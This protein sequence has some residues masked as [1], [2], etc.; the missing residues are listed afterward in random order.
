MSPPVGQSLHGR[1]LDVSKD[2]GIVDLTLKPELVK[3]ADAGAAGSGHAQE[4]AKSKS[5]KRKAAE[6]AL[7]GTSQLKVTA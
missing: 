3:A 4:K 2:T 7:E 5:K 1:V 6:A